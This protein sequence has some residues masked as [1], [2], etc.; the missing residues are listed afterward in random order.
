MAVASARR[1][2]AHGASFVL[3]GRKEEPLTREAQDLKAR[4]APVAEIQVLDL[5][6]VSA[7]DA[8]LDTARETLGGL[9]AVLVFYGV[10][11]DQQEAETSP[12]HAAMI[13]DIN[14][15]SA[16][17][18]ILAAARALETHAGQG[19][20]LL[21]A[22]SVAGDRGRRSNFVYGSAKA[23]VSVLMQGLA[24]KWAAMDNAP[25]AVNLKLGFVDTPMTDGVAKGG[26]LWAKP[27][28]IGALVE[29]AVLRP[30]GPVVY[31]PWFWRWIMLAIRATPAAIFNK[32][33][34]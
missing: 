21:T 24:H 18:W 10:L 1:L 4:G 33:N 6:D 17:H 3:V 14:Y 31:G 5:T 13:I 26:P 27:D 19:G 25:S 34:L 2:A 12:E 16:V 23:G 32:V 7:C 30:G 9:D 29:K 15:S 11:G 20:V 28:A 22:S 8:A